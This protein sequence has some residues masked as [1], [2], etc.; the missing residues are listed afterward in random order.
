MKDKYNLQDSILWH[1]GM[2]LTA[3]HF[4]QLTGRLEKIIWYHTQQIKPYYWG[5]TNLEIDETLLSHGRLVVTKLD[6]VLPD[7]LIIHIFP[8]DHESLQFDLTR[9]VNEGQQKT[10]K[11]CL[12]VPQEDVNNG[13]YGYTRYKQVKPEVINNEANLD[14]ED[15]IPFRRPNVMLQPLE[16]LSTTESSVPLVQVSF[17]N[18]QFILNDFIPPTLNVMPSSSIWK[19]VSGI[20]QKIKMKSMFLANQ[21]TQFSVLYE[22]V[23]LDK[24]FL[25]QN[26]T[27]SLPVIETILQSGNAHPYE[28]YLA[29]CNLLGHL[30]TLG[31]EL[32]MDN[33]VVYNHNDL[34]STFTQFRDLIFKILDESIGEK[35]H[36][37]PFERHDN[38]FKIKINKQWLDQ[39]LIIGLTIKSDKPERDIIYWI[40]TCLIGSEDEIPKM[41]KQRTLGIQRK[42]IPKDSNFPVTLDTIF[43]SLEIESLKPEQALIIFNPSDFP[44]D[45]IPHSINLY[46]RRRFEL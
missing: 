4:E 32:T 46:V 19:I 29:L 2:M 25:L 44:A 34:N 11:I 36:S 18:G 40:S 26:L 43:Y 20:V 10:V 27:G 12:Y 3:D 14:S 38:T 9:I 8:G 23:I 17:N 42:R 7:G 15:N 13:S 30:S 1:D 39:P 6:A 16:E 33:T 37:I 21:I 31:F 41:K 35:Y 24:R 28:L 5:V 45:A 22:P